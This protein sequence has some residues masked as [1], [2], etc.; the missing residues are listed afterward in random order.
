[1]TSEKDRAKLLVLE[2]P[3]MIF[4]I[5]GSCKLEI[6][7][8]IFNEHIF[9]NVLKDEHEYLSTTNFYEAIDK[10]FELKDE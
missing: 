5:D 7:I 2:H 1:M 8:D 6:E 10:Y 4:L 3:T 9:Y